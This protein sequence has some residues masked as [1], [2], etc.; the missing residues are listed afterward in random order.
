V[1]SFFEIPRL[2]DWH[3]HQRQGL[4]SLAPAQ[5]SDSYCS[6]VLAMPN[7]DP[8]ITR[9][10]H[11]R[12]YFYALK[13][14]FRRARLHLLFMLTLDHSPR[15]IME[16]HAAG[17]RG[18]KIYPQGVTT[19]SHL[20]IPRSALLQ[21]PPTLLASLEELAIRGMTSHSHPEMPPREITLS[22]S[23]GERVSQVRSRSHIMD[24]EGEFIV[25]LSKVRKYV[26]KL[27]MVIEHVTTKA[28]CD[29]VKE[30]PLDLV[31]ATI[32]PHHLAWDLSA[33]FAGGL[34]PWRYCKP[35]YKSPTD[36]AALW[37]SAC[38]DEHFML[39]SDSAP[40][41]EGMK[42]RDCG[43]AGVWNAPHLPATLATLFDRMDALDRLQEFSRS[44]ADRFYLGSHDWKTDDRLVLTRQ[45]WQMPITVDGMMPFMA[46]ETLDWKLE[47]DNAAT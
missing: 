7:P 31:R 30:Q 35:L 12:E 14:L 38:L 41:A 37:E 13:P 17:A 45:H 15:D 21:P 47:T 1:N 46:G 39:G 28:M 24:S 3:T 36:T 6:D 5:W 40:H 29:W 42:I 27:R 10:E 44:R 34:R 22:G 8:P 32:T 23:F 25:F 18:A 2:A 4:A 20:G 9:P 43:C 11:V 33:L 19:H 26:P 16:L